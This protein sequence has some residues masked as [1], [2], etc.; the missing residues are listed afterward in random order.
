MEADS[1]E[2]FVLHKSSAFS[3]YRTVF[4]GQAPRDRGNQPGPDDRPA[5]GGSFLG[6]RAACLGKRCG[7]GAAP[8]Q[9][10]IY[11]SVAPVV[12]FPR[13][14]SS[15]AHYQSHRGRIGTDW[16]PA[17]DGRPRSH[18]LRRRTHLPV[19]AEGGPCHGV[20]GVHHGPTWTACFGTMTL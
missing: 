5:T 4:L 2:K 11:S 13:P 14:E 3:C 16:R 19:T 1:H 9:F 10:R 6:G 15:P 20:A 8:A 12:G 17:G 7:V 18:S